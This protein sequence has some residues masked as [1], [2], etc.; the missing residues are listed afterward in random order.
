MISS[1]TYW[2]LTI[3]TIPAWKKLN[4]KQIDCLGNNKPGNQLIT[5]ILDICLMFMSSCRQLLVKVITT[6]LLGIVD[7]KYKSLWLNYTDPLVLSS[8]MDYYVIC[9][10]SLSLNVVGVFPE[11]NSC[12]NLSFPGVKC[13]QL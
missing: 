2:L 3:K 9:V 11:F 1:Y 4:K 7:M 5:F 6:E 13:W 12:L 10:C 8:V